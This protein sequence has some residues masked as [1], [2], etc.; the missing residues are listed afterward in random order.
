MKETT[1]RVIPRVKRMSEV[2]DC[3][4]EDGMRT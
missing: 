4:D 1:A 2:K 3:D